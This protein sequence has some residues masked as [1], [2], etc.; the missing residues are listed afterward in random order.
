[1]LKLMRE[2]AGSWFIKAILGAI[3]IVFIFWGVG[4]FRSERMNKVAVV[5]GTPITV[6][7]YQ[8][9][10]N[11]LIERYRSQFGDQLNEDM[12]QMFGL[13]KQ[14]LDQLINQALMLQEAEKLNLR[15][16]DD[17]LAA[18]IQAI[19]AFQ[20]EGVFDKRIYTRVLSMNR[21][22]PEEFENGQR[23]SILVEK[24]RQLVMGSVKVSDQEARD[25]YLWEN[26]SVNVE[27][28]MFAPDKYPDM[29]VTDDEVQKYFDAN[30][31]NYKTEL[32][33]KARYI[34][35][36]PQEFTAG[37][38][39]GDEAVKDYFDTHPD[40]FKVPKTVK[41]RHILFK[42]ENNSSPEVVEEKRKKAEEVLAL[43]KA[44]QDFAELAR[45]YS[46]G[47]SKD[48]GGDLGTFKKETMV[49]PFAD[50][51]FS[52][53]AGEISEP[54]R[55]QFGWHIIKVEAVNEASEKTLDEVREEIRKNMTTEKAKTL[56]YDKAESIFDAAFEGDDLKKVAEGHDVKVGETGFFTLN[57]GPEGV[58]NPVRFAG[59]ASGLA[60]M[61]IGDIQ[62]FSDGYYL[63]QVVAREPEVVAQFSDVKDKVRTD[64]I[65]VKRS[66]KAV[67]DA[68]AFLG[69][70]KGGAS[71]K[72]A[73]AKMNL[74]PK[75]TGFFK[76]ADAIPEIGKAPDIA[77][78]AFELSKNSPLPEAPITGPNGTYVIRFAERKSPEAS[79]FEPEKAAVKERLLTQKQR[80]AFGDWLAQV[81]EKSDITITQQDI[82]N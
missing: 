77:S 20:N 44:G 24:L 73:G 18:S 58:N 29:A 10:Y 31:N 45:T 40:E 2:K 76:R 19:P 17:E 1:M 26:A 6:E 56:A 46:E 59:A 48:L 53:N 8:Q 60:D 61:Q 11:S 4:N 52:M 22:S 13:K 68:K 3:V 39:V 34:Y 49:E 75:E 14:A 5:N 57:Q 42:L 62:D 43:A 54:V 74:S 55:T 9:S 50:K 33:L 30:Q 32:K 21:L 79:A 71:M 82:M 69:A 38:T 63:I 51:A 12:I 70:L 65:R 15:I 66:E 23:E 64:L 81:K 16:T 41:A 72:E 7:A 47:P 78:A 35:F 36:N 25:Y 67:V 37:V 80:G 28:V 27:F